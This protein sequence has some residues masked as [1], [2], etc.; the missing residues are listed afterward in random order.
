MGSFKNLT[1]DLAEASR[2]V[3]Q[4]AL[5]ASKRAWTRVLL[6]AVIGILV[7]GSYSVYLTHLVSEY[8]KT[9]EEHIANYGLLKQES[10]DQ[11]TL[12]YLELCITSK[13]SSDANSEYYCQKAVAL[14]K[15]TF[16]DAPNNGVAENIKRS[17]YGLMKVEV[18]NKLRI[19]V[20]ERITGKT[21][22]LDETLKF[23]LGTTGISIAVLVG[24]LA[25]VSS[26]L[27]SYRLSIRTLAEEVG[28][29]ETHLPS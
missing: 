10:W 19:L 13:K 4:L 18:A 14:Y 29:D 1:E 6:M 12:D 11:R 25:M 7:M 28:N 9:S 15:D 21:P 24:L 8:S 17:A 5:K 3:K 22:G 16:I 26:I 27:M 23:L 20:L 2:L